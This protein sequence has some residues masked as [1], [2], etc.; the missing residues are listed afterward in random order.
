MVCTPAGLC[1][2]S[3]PSSLAD[4]MKQIG[5]SY[6]KE[7]FQGNFGAYSIANDPEYPYYVCEWT[8]DPWVAELS[9]VLT[10]G[11]QKFTVHKGDW[12][13]RGIWLEKLEGARNW[14]T[15]TSN[16]QECIVRLE[17]VLDANLELRWLADDNPLPKRLKHKSGTIA[18]NRG[19]WR[20]SDE[21]HAFIIEESR[22]RDSG[23]EY[24]EDLALEAQ[25]QEEEAKVWQRAKYFSQYDS[26]DSDEVR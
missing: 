26:D 24:N 19:A 9:E 16:L 21:A 25:R 20:M 7:I 18:N 17:T 1:D 11:Y 8:G 12:L 22:N 6:A 15:T 3:I 14:L 2:G 4:T 23:Y 13:C 10:I 5:A